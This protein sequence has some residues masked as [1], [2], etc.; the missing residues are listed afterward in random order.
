VKLDRVRFFS[1]RIMCCSANGLHPSHGR[2]VIA[3][4]FNS[5]QMGSGGAGCMGG[6]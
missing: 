6:R 5:T 3:S 2:L 4:P 1:E